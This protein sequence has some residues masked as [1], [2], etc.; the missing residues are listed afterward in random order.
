MYFIFFVLK[1][2]QRSLRIWS[3]FPSSSSSSEH[4]RSPV[5]VRIKFHTTPSSRFWTHLRRWKSKQGAL[6]VFFLCRERERCNITPLVTHPNLLRSLAL[7]LLPS[8]IGNPMHSPPAALENQ[9]RLLRRR[10]ILPK[11][12]WKRFP[13]PRKYYGDCV[14]TPAAASARVN[15]PSCRRR[16][17]QATSRV[18]ERLARGSKRKLRMQQ[19]QRKRSSGRIAEGF[20]GVSFFSSE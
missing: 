11:K 2:L 9:R 20:Q 8:S 13:Y 3:L 17:S 10:K 15:T 4:P 19:R 6:F 7:L 16:A 14:P 18:Q 1:A 5:D 12:E